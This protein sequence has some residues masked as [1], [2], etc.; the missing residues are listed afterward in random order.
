ME[1]VGEVIRERVVDAVQTG[2]AKEAEK[3]SPAGF[4]S[5][6]D[7]FDIGSEIPIGVG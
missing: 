5:S 1:R 7:L 4:P 3:R 2:D 6:A